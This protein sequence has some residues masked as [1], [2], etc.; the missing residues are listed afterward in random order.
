[1]MKRNVL[2]LC[3]FFLLLSAPRIHANLAFVDFSTTPADSG[4]LVYDTNTN[5]QIATI[6]HSFWVPH[7]LAISP[8]ERFVYVSWTDSVTGDGFVSVFDIEN[9]TFVAELFLQ[10]ASTPNGLAITPDG[11][12][13]YITMSTGTIFVVDTVTNSI[14]TSFLAPGGAQP[15]GIGITP[16]GHT[17]YVGL[18]S[19]NVGV[20]NLD[21]NTFTALIPVTGTIQF[22]VV[23]TPDG[24]T[25]YV[26]DFIP[27]QVYAIATATNTITA[28]IPVGVLPWG[29]A[30]T[31][32]GQFVY[33][34]NA[35]DD[36]ISVINV[37]TNTVVALIPTP[38]GGPTWIAFTPDGLEGYVTE[39]SSG[40]VAVLST[41][42]NTF[43]QIFLQPVGTFTFSVAITQAVPHPSGLIDPSAEQALLQAQELIYESI[44]DNFEEVLYSGM[45]G[46]P[47]TYPDM[48]QLYIID[49]DTL[50]NNE[51]LL[52]PF[53]CE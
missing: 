32:N 7:I 39:Q 11:S 18:S 8:D 15:Y 28:T 10:A 5:T 20:L 47:D 25:V 34:L 30:V 17:A 42:T 45:K 37:A 41:T 33:I 21:T 40:T 22:G 13:V 50:W 24:S 3:L 12:R 35:G 46:I 44:E 16:D 27:G 43:T 53:W 52:T 2:A 49:S 1:M 31:P 23:V 19:A 14:L 9:N 29:L 36:T 26:T 51:I 6:H 48:Q 4:F 38:P